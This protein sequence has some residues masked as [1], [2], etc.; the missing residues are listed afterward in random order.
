M[1]WN[2]WSRATFFY[3]GGTPEYEK[4]WGRS[5]A[6]YVTYGLPGCPNRCEWIVPGTIVTE[7]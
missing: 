4:W 7:D 1:S 2:A 5:A 3:D 6:G